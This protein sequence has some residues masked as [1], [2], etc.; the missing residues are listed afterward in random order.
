[1][2]ERRV[3]VSGTAA[4]VDRDG[5]VAGE[6]MDALGGLFLL[7]KRSATLD[8]SAPVKAVQF[9][10]PF[11]QGN[12]AGFQLLPGDATLVRSAR[13]QVAV[14]FTESLQEKVAGPG[15]QAVVARLAADGVLPARG[16]WH[17]RLARSAYWKQGGKLF[18]WTGLLVRPSAGVWL[19]LTG[20]F[21][22]RCSVDV[23]EHVIPDAGGFVPLVVTLELA[24]VRKK[25][26]WLEK[27]LACLLPI[28]PGVT[29]TTRPLAETPAVGRAYVDYFDERWD[30]Y[31]P[32]RYLGAYRKLTVKE[33]AEEPAGSAAC[34][35]VIAGGPALHR[36][37]SFDRFATPAGWV[38]DY[39]GRER[40]QWVEVRN[41][42]QVEGL[43]DGDALRDL[44]GETPAAV[45]AMVEA[46][47][48][49][50]GDRA[51]RALARH[52][53][54]YA[55]STHG[56]RIGEPYLTFTPWAFVTTP[57]GW[58]SVVDGAH[59]PRLDGMRG[60]IST[61][62]YHGLFEVWQFVETGRF[63]IPRGAPLMRVLPVP[64]DLLRAG[65]RDVAGNGMFRAIPA[66]GA[67]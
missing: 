4:V 24:S 44:V 38:R 61:D 37:R 55:R 48:R 12:E 64:R 22:R 6:V 40:L 32:G 52:L 35:L 33:S 30:G 47:T 58:S 27:E 42:F 8:G 60:V 66:A 5:D 15:Y 1:L 49:L 56:P 46:W 34:D 39:P 23:Q 26:T 7:R 3:D 20:A 9:C 31:G 19:L 63:A 54:A 51:A 29:F 43:W 21:N 10:P 50:Y 25:D 16:Y 67:P 17:R 57:P 13:G 2:Y 28:R 18:L 36:V 45:A 53:T 65:L 11:V 59:F 41:I 14:G 62:S